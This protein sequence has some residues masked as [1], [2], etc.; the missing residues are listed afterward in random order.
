MAYDW[1]TVSWVATLGWLGAA[2]GRCGSEGAVAVGLCTG[3][4]GGWAVDEVG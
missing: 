4:G 2:L 3:T 1:A